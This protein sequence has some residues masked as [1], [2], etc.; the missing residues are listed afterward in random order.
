M[1]VR[2][3]IRKNDIEEEFETLSEAKSFAEH[4]AKKYGSVI[5]NKR[6]WESGKL[7]L[8]VNYKMNSFGD[9]EGPF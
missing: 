9:I 4:I 1:K 6:A 7:Y 2:F 5:I 8:S 3:Y